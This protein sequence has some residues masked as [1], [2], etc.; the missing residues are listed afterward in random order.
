MPRRLL[1]EI[2]GREFPATLHDTPTADA[3]WDALPLDCAYSTWGD[4]IYF[5]CGVHLSP[6]DGQETVA[7]GDVA[8][9]PPGSAICLF[10]GPTPMSG[11]GEIRAASA[12]SVFG[13]LEGDAKALKSVRGRRVLVRR[14]T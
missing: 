12:V 6:D 10:Y 9:W 5:D 2:D 7:L 14:G 1:F 3:I 13:K 8:Y 4:E 11:P